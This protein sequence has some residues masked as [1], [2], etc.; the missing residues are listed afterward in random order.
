MNYQ[1]VQS[2]DLKFG[3]DVV[4]PEDSVNPAVK[5]DKAWGLQYA[6]AMY[7]DHRNGRG[8][9]FY[10]YRDQMQENRDIARGAQDSDEFKRRVTDDDN[11]ESY[12]NIDWRVIS[13][14]ARFID[15][16]LGKMIQYDNPITLTALDQ[17]TQDQKRQMYWKKFAQIKNK[18]WLDKIESMA[19]NKVM[20][21]S[22]DGDEPQTIEELDVYSTMGTFK[23]NTE[24]AYEL[25]LQGVF[26][27]NNWREIE[28]RI[29]RD[30]LVDGIGGTKTTFLANGFPR[31]RNIDA[32]NM[33]L[34]FS[35]DCDFS[36]VPHMGEIRPYTLVELRKLAGDS[37]TDEQ[38]KAL[39]RKFCNRGG[40]N[41]LWDD[42]RWYIKG[43]NGIVGNAYDTISI[44][45][46]E[47]EVATIDSTHYKKTVS[48][49]G[50]TRM[51]K[52]DFDYNPEKDKKSKSGN[53]VSKESIEYEMLYSG[54]WIVDTEYVIGWG[55]NHNV[56]RDPTNM[57]KCFREF[58]IYAPDMLN[59]MIISKTERMIPFGNAIQISW[60]KM[61]AL[62]ASAA[63]KGYAIEISGLMD[64]PAGAKGAVIT[65]L[66]IIKM[67]RQTGVLPWSKKNIRG[68]LTNYKPM[69]EMENGIGAQMN[70]W[71]ADINFNIE[72][73]RSV[74]GINENADASTPNPNQPVYTAK[75]ALAGANNSLATITDGYKSIKLGTARSLIDKIQ[76]LVRYK[77]NLKSFTSVF[78]EGTMKV[79]E[80]G[81]DTAFSEFGIMV[82][83][84]PTDEDRA[85]LDQQIT[86]AQNQRTQNNTGGI[87][88]E[89]AI[90]IREINNVKLAARYLTVCRKR[91]E[92][93]DAKI[94]AQN[95]QNNTAAQN[96]SLM[97]ANSLKMKEMEQQQQYDLDKIHLK[98]TWDYVTWDLRLKG[99]GDLIKG[100]AGIDLVNTLLT[101]DHQEAL[102]GNQIE[103]DN[104][105]AAADPVS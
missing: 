57:Y 20:N 76:V 29:K 25:A 9:V 49:T 23:T 102:Q 79:I 18:E 92:M 104:A 73:I 46:M 1:E 44:P 31:V 101:H 58:N 16:T 95:T 80:L 7:A 99:Q 96:Q 54:C 24:I 81:A 6:K 93:M 88:L 17:L 59:G 63:P 13:V 74:T 78:G 86:T 89:D 83:D 84:L 69:E 94:A 72:M 36:S 35:K 11:E 39:A 53:T 65:P 70:E 27:M 62:K 75:L 26:Y 60:L 43:R 19:G 105:N 34:P 47:F 56:P 68:D 51:F 90:R 87:E 45:V 66:E 5:K 12:L 10:E 42:D 30:L 37:L 8:R 91:R 52:T 14:P 3:T 55:A 28:K 77:K 4:Y 48:P 103:A 82:D 2:K 21:T 22:S 41:L 97:T 67:Q 85:W 15:A 32:M 50:N 61:Q 40:N 38:Y 98:G 33:V 71:V 64:V 100:K